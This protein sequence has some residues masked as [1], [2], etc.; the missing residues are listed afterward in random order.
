MNQ[1]FI[2][3]LKDIE[4]EKN[5]DIDVILSA[6]EA[7]LL[8]ACKNNLGSNAD[9]DVTIDRDTG[10]MT[11][12]A[13]KEVVE[14][15]EKEGAEISL[16]DAVKINPEYQLG[17]I[18]VVKVDPGNFGR[19]AATKAKQV[20]VQ[21]I[22]EAERG[23]LNEQ[24]KE[25]EQEL[26]SGR[27]QRET[28]GNIIINIGKVDAVM[29]KNECVPR[30]RY[31]PNSRIKVFIK[32]IRL[33]EQAGP[34]VYV[35]RRD[36]RLVIRLFEREVPEVEDGTVEIKEISREAGSRTKIA[37]YSNNPGVDPIGACVGQNGSRVN[38]IVDDLQGEKID[39]IPWSED[40]KTFIASALSPAKVLK[41]QV[42]RDEKVA[43]VVVPDFQLSL[44]IGKDGQ[45]A[46]LAARL[47]DYRIDIRSETKAEEENFIDEELIVEDSLNEA[48]GGEDLF[49]DI[50]S[51][52]DYDFQEI[53]L[54]EEDYEI[55][56]PTPEEVEGD[57]ELQISEEFLE[58]EEKTEYEEASEEEAK[59]EVAEKE[60][61]ENE[62]S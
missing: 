17:D 22:R 2:L 59:D 15:V 6:V 31:E 1:E 40:I 12:L 25:K 5:I 54:S 21:K 39:I 11:I 45:N 62:E 16:E 7:S 50:M 37:V 10:D 57:S 35:S 36:K 13:K 33:D 41:V 38:V 47:T 48:F 51:D 20:V 58:K 32:E 23:V 9:I 4:R 30:E 19:I 27:I 18:A 61:D 14:V 60:D 49:L 34:K 26:I 53:V 24:F 3:A 46:K 28:N 42:L 44:A 55:V 56:L 43:R 8:T 52:S 29:K